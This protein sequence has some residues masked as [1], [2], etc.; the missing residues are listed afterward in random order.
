MKI[1]NSIGP[2]T[3]PWG[4]PEVT[5]QDFDVSP[6]MTTCSDRPEMNE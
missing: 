1:R 6:S 4:N 5:G 3:V 2:K